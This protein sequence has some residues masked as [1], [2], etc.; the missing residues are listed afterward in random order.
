MNSK[1]VL[2]KEFQYH[3][4]IFMC[5]Y[6]YGYMCSCWEIDTT[7]FRYLLRDMPTEDKKDKRGGRSKRESPDPDTSLKP[8]KKREK[9]SMKVSEGS[10]AQRKYQLSWKGV[11]KHRLSFGRV[12]NQAEVAGL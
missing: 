10:A 9:L 4:Y 2:H 3:I 6:I 12:R 11:T 1:S 7:S 5:V 8:I